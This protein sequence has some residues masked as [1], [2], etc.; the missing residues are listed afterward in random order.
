MKDLARLLTVTRSV[1]YGGLRGSRTRLVLI[2]RLANLPQISKG[3]WSKLTLNPQCHGGREIL[4]LGSHGVKRLSKLDHLANG[5]CRC[6]YLFP[7]HFQDSVMEMPIL[8]SIHR[9][10]YAHRG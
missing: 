7:V 2:L 1:V 8:V 10:V 9:E 4:Q 3:G 5:R 6:E